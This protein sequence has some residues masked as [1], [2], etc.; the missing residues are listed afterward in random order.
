MLREGT[1]D[2]TTIGLITFVLGGLG[3]YFTTRWKIRKDLES[4]YGRIV[5][6][7]RLRTY[8]MLWVTLQPFALYA[9]T[10]PVTNRTVQE[11]AVSLRQWYF[12]TGGMFLTDR[13]RDAYFAVQKALAQY[14]S[15]HP[16]REE[17]REEDLD[18]SAFESIRTLGSALR[19]ALVLD[20]GTRRTDAPQ[21]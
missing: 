13:S 4:E 16:Y 14:L 20:L 6:E 17:A 8:P 1:I 3:T 10:W 2:E 21:T 9:R 5:R 15:I 11:L 7:A 19:T 18:P 12:E